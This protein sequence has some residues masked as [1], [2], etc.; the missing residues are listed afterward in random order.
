MVANT[1]PAKCSAADLLAVYT[2]PSP[3]LSDSILLAV[4]TDPSPL[5]SDSY[6]V[7]SVSITSLV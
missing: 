6:L 4:Y 7:G 2:D 3:L 1:T 5:L